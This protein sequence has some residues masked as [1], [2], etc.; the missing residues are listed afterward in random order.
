M[1]FTTAV[2]LAASVASAAVAESDPDTCRLWM[3][4]SNLGTPYLAKFGLYAGVDYNV[5]ELLPFPE[6]ALPFVDF[7]IDG[8]KNTPYRRGILE[9]LESQFWLQDYAGTKFEGNVSSTAFVP[10]LGALAAYHSGVYN[11]EI[12]Q[13]AVWQRSRD[14]SMPDSGKADTSRGAISTFHNMTLKVTRT[15]PA[16]MELFANFGDVW[17]AQRDTSAFQDK[18]VRQDYADADKIV[19][20][21]T[22]YFDKF[23]DMSDELKDETLD[24]ML[25]SILNQAGGF[26]AKALQ[27]LIPNNWRHLSKVQQAG[28]TFEYRFPD[29]IKTPAWLAK[30]GMCVDNMEMKPS[31]IKGA[32]RGAFARRPIDKDDVISPIPTT[33]IGDA[34]LLDMYDLSEGGGTD[35]MGRP[36]PPGNYYNYTQ[37]RGQQIALNYCYGHP[38]SSLLLLPLAPTVNYINHADGEDGS[39]EPNAVLRWSEHEKIMNDFATQD[40]LI[41]DVVNHRSHLITL[42][43]VAVRD[44]KPGEEIFIDYGPEWADAWAD[45]SSRATMAKGGK[46]PLKADDIRQVFASKAYPVKVTDETNPYPHGTATACF[47]TLH[48][49]PDGLPHYNADGEDVY[50]W[51]GDINNVKGADLTYCDLLDRVETPEGSWNYTVRTRFNDDNFI[52]VRHVP[53]G[54][55][56]VVDTP[57]NSDMHHHEAFRFPIGIPDEIWPQ[58]WRDLR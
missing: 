45:Y 15:I 48:A 9:W 41:P 34:S 39:P 25:R 19:Q 31:T 50:H 18:V 27:S 43:L 57:Y 17:D 12:L 22:D 21:I 49:V 32:G 44:I 4:P 46:W 55:I 6:L 8:N 3:A 16:G 1:K 53:H 13:H 58:H 56:T 11:V 23:P 42:E 26:R 36:I 7:F 14:P 24:F 29:M 52:E 10:G 38:E 51:D 28:G 37:P 5:D 40:N 20:R 35:P 33:I 54:A 47:M 30:N 2:V